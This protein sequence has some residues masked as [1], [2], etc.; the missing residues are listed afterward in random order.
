MSLYG[1]SSILSINNSLKS[2]FFSSLCVISYE[3]RDSQRYK[4]SLSYKLNV[5]RKEKHKKT[6]N[7]KNQLTKAIKIHLEKLAF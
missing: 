7:K 2:I 6:F 3:N 5:K 4:K 1:Y